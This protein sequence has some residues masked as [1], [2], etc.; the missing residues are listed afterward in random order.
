MKVLTFHGK[1]IAE[2]KAVV[3]DDAR[4]DFVAAFLGMRLCRGVD[5]PNAD[6]AYLVE[7][8][9]AGTSGN[10]TVV[11]RSRRCEYAVPSAHPS[12]CQSCL[13][14]DFKIR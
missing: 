11:W 14:L 13:K 1:V 5:R 3:S 12:S 10:D 8:A 7:E 2:S 9:A 4:R 6:G